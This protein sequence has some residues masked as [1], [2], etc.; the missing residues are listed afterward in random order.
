M[1]LFCQQCFAKVEY[2]FSKPKFC[3]ECGSQIGLAS[4][5]TESKP[6]IK[7]NDAQR[8]KELEAQLNELKNQKTEPQRVINTSAR[9]KNYQD[10]DD[11]DEE[12]EDLDED[13][14]ETQRHIDN[15][16]R[17]KI[18]NGIIVE[19]DFNNKGI[20]F[21]QLMENVS[22]GNAPS[23]DEFKMIDDSPRKTD[24]QIL[25]ELRIEASSKPRPIQID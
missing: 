17:K 19:K 18:K 2:K 3:P 10:N 5:K 8:I 9:Y 22:S 11:Y 6:V 4:I 1:K 7:N 23:V 21:G 15:F 25:D 20:S 12:S 14:S 13:Y 16:K 24:Q